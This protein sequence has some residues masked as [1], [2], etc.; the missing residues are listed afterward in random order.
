MSLA[1][2]A[3]PPLPAQT[4]LIFLL[5]LAVL[6]FIARSLG[7]LAQKLRMPA[8][9]GE[10]MTGVLLGP[11]VLGH[12]APELAA[13]LLPQTVSQAGLLDAIGQFCV[14]LLVGV[15]GAHLDMTMIRR[16][17]ATVGRISAFGLTLPLGLGI[18]VGYA[19]PAQFVPATTTREI[20]AVFL[21]I[22]MCVSALPVI[23]KTLADMNLLHRDTGQLTLAS[24]MVDDV[25]GWLLLSLVS[26]A[27]T[28][29]LTLGGAVRAVASLIGFC[30]VAILI[31]RPLIRAQLRRA[32]RAQ[33]PGPTMATA[34]IAILAGAVIAQALHIEA[35]F[36]AFVIGIIIGTARRQDV[37][38]LAPLRTVVLSVLA[39]LFLATAGLRMDLT[40]LADADVAVAAVVVLT[41][42]IFGKF[43]GAYLGARM[44]RLG[45]WEGLAIG[46]GMNARGVIEVIVALTGLRLGV[47]NTATYTIVTL[48]ALVTSVMAPP[49]LRLASSR[50]A[51]TDDEA[52]RREIHETLSRTGPNPGPNPEP[53]AS[54]PGQDAVTA[55]RPA[56]S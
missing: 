19:L 25:V 49:I 51:L 43:A 54:L 52:T 21:G 3:V 56:A 53:E 35:V 30:A 42:A 37:A 32:A 11:S 28:I 39:P 48:V 22:A 36:G 6:L 38:R 16:R 23:A 18:G 17:G 50:I 9:V 47:L 26:A 14:L 55:G 29:G 24:A 31:G 27:A 41:I 5:Q 2:A 33:E 8:I 44:S 15:T 46:A 40:A 20:F 45:S 7:A 1:A 34:V 10:L 12:T 13:R 4:V